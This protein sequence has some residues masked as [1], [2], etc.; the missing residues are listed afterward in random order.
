MVFISPDVTQFLKLGEGENEGL[1]EGGGVGLQS[2][3]HPQICLLSEY[4]ISIS[5]NQSAYEDLTTHL[6]VDI[7]VLQVSLRD[8][9]NSLSQQ[10]IT[11]RNVQNKV[12]R[13]Y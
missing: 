10:T 3:Q 9:L 5:V 8:Y 7:M 1:R 11:I 4:S 13:I 2:P 12:R 6:Y